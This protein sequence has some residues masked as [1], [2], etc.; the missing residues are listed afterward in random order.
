MTDFFEINCS[1]DFLILAYFIR[2]VWASFIFETFLLQVEVW[3][4]FE[5]FLYILLNGSKRNAI[6]VTYVNQKQRMGG[7]WYMY[8]FF[9]IF[10]CKE[11]S[12]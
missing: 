11:K 12:F 4:I 8:M 3:V 7:L 1:F 5:A 9:P 2:I 6:I 10:L